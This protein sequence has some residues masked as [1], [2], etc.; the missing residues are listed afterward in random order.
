M[1]HF[2]LNIDKIL[3]NW[4][5]VHACRE[6]IANALDEAV[7]TDSRTPIIE[8]R[9]SNSWII[10]DYGR[11]LN[12][13][14]LIQTENKEKLSNSYV[15][16]KFGIGLKDALATFDR[17]GIKVMLR[18]RYGDIGLKRAA[19]H[20][21][22]DIITLHAVLYPPS[23]PEMIGTECELFGMDDHDV[24]SA[25]EMFLRFS[26]AELIESTKF[27]DVYSRRGDEGEIFINGMKVASEPNFLFSYNITD[28]T[29]Q[30]R[31]ALNRERQNLGRT[32]YAERVKAIL[33][34]CS[35]NKII[36]ML[37]NDL[38]SLATGNAHEELSWIEI[39]NFAVRILNS[40][41]NV[42][43]VSPQELANSPNIKYIAEAMNHQIISIP[44]NLAKR[45]QNTCDISGKPVIDTKELYH[46]HSNS[47]EFKW[48][49]PK[50]LSK[51]ELVIWN[52]HE[53]IL[54]FMGGKPISVK[55]IQISETMR[56]DPIARREC[57]GLWIPSQG[58]IVIHRSQLFSL[59]TFASTLLHEAIHAKYGV[60]DLS[61]E[62]ERCLSDLSG[63]LA[64][65]L[66]NSNRSSPEDT[67][68]RTETSKGKKFLDYFRIKRE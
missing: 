52:L 61:E 45:I 4:T 9:D 38:E 41:K 62:F 48:V 24:S 25:K 67:P 12:H 19:K 39:Q 18:S 14:S 16:G 30:L 60:L 10:R 2:D 33:L 66:V 27:G 65:Q 21:F 43:F 55:E 47:F 34:A 6:L 46:Q 40:K 26:N 37:S 64:A 3:E 54:G 7:L 15:I 31:K 49:D 13:Q 57:A 28:L 36:T 11:G 32:A 51:E 1:K 29:T 58:W 8:K 17:Q 63:N 23:D 5:S 50:F 20:S 22:D 44:D 42:V 68:K 59:Q 53:K 35:S 56:H